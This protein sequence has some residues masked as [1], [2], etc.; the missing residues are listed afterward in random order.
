MKGY[1]TSF[2]AVDYNGN[3]CANLAFPDEV[4]QCFF[5]IGPKFLNSNTC[6]IYKIKSSPL[7]MERIVII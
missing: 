2:N 6:I 1:D 7:F 4:E 5:E 3:E